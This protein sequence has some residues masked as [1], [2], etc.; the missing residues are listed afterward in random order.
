M[1]VV[2]LHPKTAL[3]PPSGD[4]SSIIAAVDIGSSKIACL[5]GQALPSRGRPG[6]EAPL[7]ILGLGHQA[8][9]GVRGGTVVDVEEAERAIRLAVDAAERMAQRTISA[10]Y[11][12]VSGGRPQSTTYRATVQVPS[13]EVTEPDVDAAIIAALKLCA[14]GKRAIM[15]VAPGRFALDEAKGVEHPVGMFGDQLTAEVNVVTA[16]AA[17]LRNLSQAVA[18]CHLEVAGSAV[19]SYAAA[20]SVLA[21]D[22]LALGVTLIDMGSATTGVSVF[23]DG[24]LVFADSVP[25]GGQHITNDIAQGLST[26]IA[27][28]ERMKTLWGS[29]IASGAD[30][31]ES[32]QVPLLGERGADT[33]HSVPKSLL[34]GIIR[35]RLEEIYDLMRQRIAASPAAR[36][37]AARAVLT[38]GGSQL[39]GAREMASHWFS[40]Q[41]RAGGPV[42]LPGMPDAGNTPGFAVAAGLLLYALNPDRHFAIPPAQLVAEAP[43]SKSYVRR[44]G[45]WLAESL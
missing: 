7:R 44:V 10:I 35:P 17:A 41:V 31:R 27:H 42:P 38:G 6:D 11:V 21:A 2:Q 37:G 20:K 15:H 24:H 36:L 13:G 26:T 3:R 22:E 32:I 40:T 4:R 14:P 9:R 33:I 45:R 30:D 25:L 8:A 34:T 19:A 39:N 5:I 23:Y 43:Q 16:D 1:T 29:A 28:A 12:N 18:R